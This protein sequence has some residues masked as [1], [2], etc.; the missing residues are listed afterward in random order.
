M[1][2]KRN[3]AEGNYGQSTYGKKVLRKWNRIFLSTLAFALA[4]AIAFLSFV[5]DAMADLEIRQKP[6]PFEKVR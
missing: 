4:L 2:I 5:G 6:N 1:L 3:Y